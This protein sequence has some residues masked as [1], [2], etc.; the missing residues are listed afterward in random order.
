MIK[1]FLK[2]FFIACLA[3]VT[4]SACKPAS[5][6][7]VGKDLP[8]DVKPLRIGYMICDG[9]EEARARFEP[10][11]RYLQAESGIPLEAVYLNTFGAGGVRAR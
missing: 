2:Y 3:L 7:P 6:A 1:Q 9:V 11:T 10:L 5:E 4:V 8:G